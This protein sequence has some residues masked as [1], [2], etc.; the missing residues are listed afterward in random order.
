VFVTFFATAIIGGIM[1]IFRIALVTKRADMRILVESIRTAYYTRNWSAL[2]IP[3]YAKKEKLP[4]AM[5]I[6]AG[7]EVCLILEMR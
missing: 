7:A 6:S 3:Q 2:E 5:A 4:Y 1:A